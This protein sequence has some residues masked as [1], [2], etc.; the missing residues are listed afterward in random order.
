V[1]ATNVNAKRLKTFKKKRG[2]NINTAC[3]SVWYVIGVAMNAFWKVNSTKQGYIITSMLY[4]AK[5]YT[6][7]VGT[8]F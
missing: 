7:P 4:L 3:Q 6:N 5:K 8:N 1:T 2:A